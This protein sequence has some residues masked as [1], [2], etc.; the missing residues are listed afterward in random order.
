VQFNVS[1]AVGG[2]NAG[3]DTVIAVLSV[4]ESPLESVTVSATVYVAAV[5]YV[6]VPD[7]AVLAVPSPNVHERLVI[8]PLPAVDVSANAQS[9]YVQL[10]VRAAVGDVGGG[11]ASAFPDGTP[12]VTPS[13]RAVSAG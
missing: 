7:S 3:A 4:S 9:R 10:T 5:A 11:G 6:C 1:A 12:A 2:V 13:S 8:V